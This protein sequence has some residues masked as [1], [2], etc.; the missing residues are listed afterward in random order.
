MAEQRA[1]EGQRQGTGFWYFMICIPRAGPARPATVS[2]V[3]ERLGTG[4]K[5]P[6]ADGAQLIELLGSWSD[7]SKMQVPAEAGNG[8][9]SGSP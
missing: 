7:G 4:E 8:E 2:G 5:R 1:P 6:F 9:E 3:I